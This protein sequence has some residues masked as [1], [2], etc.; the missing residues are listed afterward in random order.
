MIRLFTL[1]GFCFS[2][3]R[4]RFIILLDGQPV[5]RM[6]WIEYM[7][8]FHGQKYLTGIFAIY[9]NIFELYNEGKMILFTLFLTLI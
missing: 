7:L 2:G 8:P 3:S 1:I 4:Y 5:A 9:A 6:Q